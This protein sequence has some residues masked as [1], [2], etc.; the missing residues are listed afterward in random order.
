MSQLSY[1]FIAAS[2][3]AALIAAEPR[4]PAAR[5]INSTISARG[6]QNSVQLIY[7]QSSTENYWSVYKGPQGVAV[8]VC[9]DDRFQLIY[10]ATAPHTRE[11]EQPPFLAADVKWFFPVAPGYD[12]QIVG[13]GQ[14]PGQLRCDDGKTMMMDFYKDPRYDGSS[15]LCSDGVWYHHA[16]FAEF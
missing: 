15:V 5:N 7:S 4:G 13:T 16:W 6:Y 12:C 2:C 14:D 9:G 3:L 10:P 11:L 8:N 1:R